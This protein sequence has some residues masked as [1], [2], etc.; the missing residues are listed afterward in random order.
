MPANQ[1]K[2]RILY[3]ITKSNFGGAQRY[4]FEL[5]TAMK[6]E[7]CEIA[8]ACGGNGLLID[9]L[10][11]A[12]ISVYTIK[13][14]QR[15]ISFKKEILSIFELAKII[16]NFNPDIVHLNSSKAGGTGAFISRLLGVPLVIFTVHG[17]PYLEPRNFI[18]KRMAWLGS[19][20]TSLL[21]HIVIVV[22]ENDK[23]CIPTS[24][25]NTK[26]RMINTAVP[27]IDFLDRDAARTF[28]FKKEKSG[29]HQNDTW[30]I[31]N[32]ELNH[33]KN[34]LVAID[35]ISEYNETH[36]NKIFYS[37]MGEG[38]LHKKITQYIKRK[39]M[40]KYVTL[41]GY[42][43]DGRKYLKAF[44]IFLLPSKK[45]GLPYSIL[46]AG[47][48]GL[49]TIASNVGGIPEIIIDNTT[50]KLIDPNSYTSILIALEDYIKNP[51]DSLNEA[52]SLQ[53][54]VQSAYALEQ[55][56]FDTNE[57][58]TSINSRT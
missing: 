15:N 47:A 30:L 7:G 25:I 8:V 18:W 48:A 3:V 12:D 38:E 9:K 11:E 57:I 10:K 52:N 4:V 24:F 21:S 46:E 37:I 51:S 32:A 41:L 26:V 44:D 55:M 35:A 36:Q 27:N 54:K 43:N 1:S 17:W 14:F 20:M 49:P 58:Y 22:S 28:L 50:G 40:S 23:R 45:E 2:K 13:N 16:R 42:I 31:T 56:I 19:L 5:A 39:N 29:L 53:Q 6:S 34:L 33:N